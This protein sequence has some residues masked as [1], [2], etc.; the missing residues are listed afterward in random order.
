MYGYMYMLFISFPLVFQ[1]RYHFS[2]GTV[3][4]S[5]LGMGIG[6]LIGLAFAGSMSEKIYRKKFASGKWKPEYR[7]V[8]VI[9]CCFF[10]PIGLFWYGWAAQAGT[11]WIVP[12]LGTVFIGIGM[13]V[14]MV[15][16]LIFG[17]TFQ[18]YESLTRTTDV[19]SYLL[20]RRSSAVRSLSDCYS[21]CCT[22]ANRKY[23]STLRY[24]HIQGPGSGMGQ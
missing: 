18:L 17:P 2:T 21:D 15:C 3:G 5:Y 23:C 11:H 16:G 8:P 13:N 22:V 7:L 24:F 6:S 4:L 20:H 19:R 1:S 9:P 10:I 14:L 12:I